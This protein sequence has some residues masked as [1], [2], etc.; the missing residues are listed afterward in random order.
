MKR[1][2]KILDYENFGLQFDVSLNYRNFVEDEIEL[3]IDEVL[4]D[5]IYALH[6][7]LYHETFI[8]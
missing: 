8:D 1:A 3:P 4:M 5:F 6:M 2:S 7:E